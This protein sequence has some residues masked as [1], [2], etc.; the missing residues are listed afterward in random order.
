MLRPQVSVAL[1]MAGQIE[2][3]DPHCIG[4]VKDEGRVA[5]SLTC[6]MMAHSLAYYRRT[7]VIQMLREG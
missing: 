5:E 3:V 2:T 6:M 1:I 4:T 7:A